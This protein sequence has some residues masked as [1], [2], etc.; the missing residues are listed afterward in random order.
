MFTIRFQT[1]GP[2]DV[3]PHAVTR[4]VQVSSYEIVRNG[5]ISTVYFKDSNDQ[6]YAERVG[7]AAADDSEHP[8]E[9]WAVAFVMN[10]KGSTID[11]I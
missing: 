8:Q 2:Q 7:P 3:S 1:D 5:H 9:P 10:D 6:Q 11:R 4:V